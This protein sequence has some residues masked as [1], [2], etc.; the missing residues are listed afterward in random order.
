MSVNSHLKNLIASSNIASAIYNKVF[1][2]SKDPYFKIATD[3]FARNHYAYIV[4]YGALAA[5]S[6]GLD[7]IAVLEFGVA[8]GA[9]LVAMEDCASEIGA[10]LS[11]RIDV[12]GFDG[13]AGMPPPA[14]FRDAPHVWREFD[15]KMDVDALTRGLRTARLHLGYLDE[16]IRA[17]AAEG[18][19]PIAA[20]AFDL[21]YY[22]ATMQAFRSSTTNP[23][24]PESCAIST[25][26]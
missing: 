7:R 13:G 23:S 22:S 17:F 16:T 25:T 12:H 10:A 21:D 24:F 18:H 4:Y 2:A 8:G 3:G 14:D 1:P 26:S 5:K 20:M 11:I 6:L 9:G 19:A 15:F